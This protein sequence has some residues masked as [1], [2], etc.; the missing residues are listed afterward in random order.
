M[1]DGDT[2]LALSGWCLT[3]PGRRRGR[4][5]DS[6]LVCERL[7]V[8]AVA[9][10]MGGHR[11]GGHASRLALDVLRSEVEAWLSGDRPSDAPPREAAAAAS[12]AFSDTAEVPRVRPE[13]VIA[14]EAVAARRFLHRAAQRASDAIFDAA[15]KDSS[16]RGM[17]T[18][19]TA[20]LAS[21][22]RAYIVHAGDSRAYRMRGGELEQVTEDHSWTREQVKAGMMTEAE[23]EVSEYRHVI[24]RSIGFER[25][26]HLD[27]FELEL[28]AGDR[29]LLCSDG[30]SN[31]IGRGELAPL[32]GETPCKDV[33]ARLVALANERGGEDNITAVVVEVSASPEP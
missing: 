19:L 22:E 27:V 10:G 2:H 29:F 1:S 30:L 14:G 7:S 9:D 25:N 5:E 24:T 16:L 33:P 28:C 12:V 8:Y 15:R 26:V 31:Y 11:G 18:T 4:N 21:G 23:A 3:D 6:C 20:M 13:D 17:G 32:M